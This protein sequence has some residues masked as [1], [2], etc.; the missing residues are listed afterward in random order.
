MS[1][2]RTKNRHLPPHMAIRTYTNSRGQTW[3]GYYYQGIRDAEGRRKLIP[4][5]SDL[6]VALRKWAE[7]EGKPTVSEN[8]LKNIYAKYI[9]WA[10]QRDISG[11]SLVSIRDYKAHWKMLS[12]VFADAPIDQIQPSHIIR[13]F[14]ARESKIRGKK[15]IKFL[16]TLFNWAKAR[17]YAQGVN[18]TTGV[19]RQMKVQ[20]KRTIYVTDTDFALVRKN[21]IQPVQDAMDIALLTGQRPADV[22]KMRWTDIE[23]GILTVNQ[24]KTGQTVHIAINGQLK[25]TLAAIRKRPYLSPWIINNHGKKLSDITFRRAFTDARDKAEAEAKETGIPFQRFQFKDLRAK[26]ATDSENHTQAQKLL[27]HKHAAT[28]DIYRRNDGSTVAPLEKKI[29]G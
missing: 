10:E 12:K 5:G 28:T 26:A 13:Y 4:L 16:S 9:K 1:G 29:S 15:E 22:F 3:T 19:T 2:I 27:G 6:S 25:K 18:P 7:I 20:T 21:A 24:N 11:L 17:G 8:A 23:N 14:D